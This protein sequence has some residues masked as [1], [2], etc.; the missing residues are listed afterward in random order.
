L[1]R[2]VQQPVP[3]SV[4]FVDALASPGR[5]RGFEGG[6]EPFELAELVLRELLDCKLDRERLQ[7]APD[8]VDLDRCLGM[9]LRDDDPVVWPLVDETVGLQSSR[10]PSLI[11]VAL[12]PSNLV[13]SSTARRCPGASSPD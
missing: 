13:N 1:G 4:R 10:S 7:H 8:P 5:H 3:G 12:I 9:Q 11:G 2:V 6:V